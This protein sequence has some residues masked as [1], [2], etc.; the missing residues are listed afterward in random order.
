MTDKSKDSS[1]IRI[2]KETILKLKKLKEK[3]PESYDD[4][5]N[6]LIKAYREAK[7]RNGKKNE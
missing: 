3:I 1:M 7:K 5:I 6:K 4:V 2:R